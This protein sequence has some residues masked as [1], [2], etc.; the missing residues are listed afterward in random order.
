[1]AGILGD[2]KLIQVG[3]IVKNL[4]ESRAKYAAF[5]G[6]PEP[7][8]CDG[9]DFAVTGT[10]VNGE[11]APEANC[12]M[13]FFDAGNGMQIELIEPNQAKSTW[14]DFLEQHGEG[15]HHLGF[16]V[17]GSEEKI[18]ACQAAGMPCTQR[19]K[20]GDGSGEYAYMD[21]TGDLKCFIET[22]ESYR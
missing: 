20:Y 17:K 11:P 12:R 5:L 15:I 21:A 3:I 2:T 6:V 16:A 4:E 8:I 13:A 1:M 7:P 10:V 22:L 9:G 19:G 14:R 18:A